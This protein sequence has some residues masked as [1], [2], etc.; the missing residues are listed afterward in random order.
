MNVN[1]LI[2]RE[3]VPDF[4]RKVLKFHVKSIKK[5]NII[6]SGISTFSDKKITIHLIQ[7]LFISS[8]TSDSASGEYSLAFV[9]KDFQ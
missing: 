7:F 1:D 8:L 9:L 4:T 3:S 6:I 5:L 2:L